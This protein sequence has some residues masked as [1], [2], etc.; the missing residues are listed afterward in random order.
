MENSIE[1]IKQIILGYSD[2]YRKKL[3]NWFARQNDTT[4]IEVFKLTQDYIKR[5]TEN[6]QPTPQVHFAFFLKALISMSSIEQKLR[7]KELNSNEIKKAQALII[8]RIKTQ[9]K[10]KTAKKAY[11]I[12]VLFYDLKRLHE[13]ENL[14]FNDLVNYL[15]KMHKL[16]V[17]KAYLIKIYNK[18]KTNQ[19]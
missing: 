10:S 3:I 1:E 12:K 6:K 9:K 7:K 18:L 19:D 2:D 17:T 16:K 5:Y 11:K 4:Q 8:N 13:E 14:S 15:S